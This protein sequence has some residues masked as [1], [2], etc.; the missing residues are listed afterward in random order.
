MDTKYKTVYVRTNNKPIENIRNV[1]KGTD[2]LILLLY[3]MMG[4]AKSLAGELIARRLQE[5]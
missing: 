2:I 4:K 5:Q 1:L 3:D